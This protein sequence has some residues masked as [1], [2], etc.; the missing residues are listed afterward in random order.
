[1]SSQT[2]TALEEV[3]KTPTESGYVQTPVDPCKIEH[4]DPPALSHSSS[5]AH[6][7]A[8]YLLPLWSCSTQVGLAVTPDGTSV[9]QLPEEHGGAHKDPVDPV[10]EAFTSSAWHGGFS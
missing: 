5:F 4:E 2:T 10:T 1:V 9:G 3:I 6:S 7:K 8:Q